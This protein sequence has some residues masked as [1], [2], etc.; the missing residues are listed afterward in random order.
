M[1]AHWHN[2]K[3]DILF[4]IIGLVQTLLLVILVHVFVNLAGS[5]V[6]IINEIENGY[7]RHPYKIIDEAQRVRKVQTLK[8]D[9]WPL[10]FIGCSLP[11]CV[12]IHQI[13]FQHL[14][15]MATRRNTCLASIAIISASLFMVDIWSGIK[16]GQGM[17]IETFYRFFEWVM[18]VILLFFSYLQSSTRLKWN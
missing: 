3:P 15:G 5:E 8:Y 17:D 4:I 2:W 18:V 11:S 6:G 1:K 14:S 7:P 10:L 16:A 13:V 9:F 12:L